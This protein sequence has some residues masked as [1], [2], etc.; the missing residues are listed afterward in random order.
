MKKEITNIAA[1]VRTRLYNLAQRHGMDFSRTLLLYIQERVLFRISHSPYCDHFILKGGVLFYGAHGKIARPTKDLDFYIREQSNQPQKLLLIFQKIFS[2]ETADGLIFD[3]EEIVLEPIKGDDEYEG[4]RVKIPVRLEQARQVV[5]IDLGFNDVV[6]PAPVSF[7]YPVMLDEEPIQLSAYSWESVIAEKFEA[8]VKLGEANSRIKDIYDIHHLALNCFFQ[9]ET[10]K[11]AMIRTFRNR[12]TVISN[13]LLVFSAVFRENPTKQ[14]Q[15]Q[16]FL[17]KSLINTA[18]TFSQII[19]EIDHFIRPVIMAI[20]SNV[21]FQ[22]T[23]NPA[24]KKWEKE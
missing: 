8:M 11:T 12:K 1:S 13:D 19:L 22:N 7:S 5:Q 2:I 18:I 14:I 16:A 23:W 9:G 6:Y 20:T 17:K 24:A 3:L 21:K 10:L 4:W 15:W